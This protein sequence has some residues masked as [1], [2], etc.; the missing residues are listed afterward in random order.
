MNGMVFSFVMEQIR[1]LRGCRLRRHVNEK[2]LIAPSWLLI[3]S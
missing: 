1:R 2:W 3:L